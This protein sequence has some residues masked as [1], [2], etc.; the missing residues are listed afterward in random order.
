[1]ARGNHWPE[2]AAANGAERPWSS[3]PALHRGA[4][5]LKLNDV[6]FYQTLASSEGKNVLDVDLSVCRDGGLIR[7]KPNVN[8]TCQQCEI[9][10]GSVHPNNKK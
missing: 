2:E 5:E 7:Q 1:M 9:F 8:K 3:V 6:L 10:K 4:N